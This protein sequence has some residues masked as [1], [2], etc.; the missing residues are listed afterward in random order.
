MEATP[1]ELQPAPSGDGRRLLLAAAL[2]LALHGGVLAAF[3]REPAMEMPGEGVIDVEVVMTQDAPALPAAP[4]T[5][6]VEA[7]QTDAPKGSTGIAALAEPP[8]PPPFVTDPE[9]APPAPVEPAASEA[10]QPRL[11]APVDL[12]DASAPQAPL[13]AAQAPPDASDDARREASLTPEDSPA[14][15][16]P[17][18]TPEPARSAALVENASPQQ[19]APA[20][21]AALASPADGMATPQTPPA[22]AATPDAADD[23]LKRTQAA[24]AAR[25]A[26]QAAQ[27]RKIREQER[28]AARAE[29]R[30]HEARDAA[31]Q[32]R[33]ETKQRARLQA[34]AREKAA[35]RA[36]ARREAEQAQAPRRHLA[37]AAEPAASRAEAP[38]RSS[39]AEIGA[40]R[41]AVAARVAAMKRYPAGARGRGE[42]GRPVV[43]FSVAASG[44]LG[45]VSLARSS[46][47]TELDAEALSMVRR[48]APFP[49]P[50]AGAPR[51]FSIGVTFD[52]R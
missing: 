8:P 25:L 11:A 16:P 23:E 2:S 5:P 29:V 35:T 3:S 46:G 21:T 36:A 39:G 50:P 1:L 13:E 41:S 17:P 34:A 51:S 26:E 19:E 44:G 15:P 24:Q 49:R 47:H 10:D 45:G 52:L 32:A 42:T 18:A 40:F 43:A 38:A 20:E 12:D 9:L 31:A 28:L 30:R 27:R 4:T 14:S 33:E 6:S 48:A 7:R 22:L 37:R